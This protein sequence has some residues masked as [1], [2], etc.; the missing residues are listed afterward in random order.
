M[1]RLQVFS[2]GLEHFAGPSLASFSSW[3]RPWWLK[4]Y[5]KSSGVF[6]L[7]SLLFGGP[8]RRIALGYTAYRGWLGVGT[9]FCILIPSRI[10]VWDLVY[11]VSCGS[12]RRIGVIFMIRRIWWDHTPYRSSTCPDGLL[13]ARYA[14]S[15]KG[16][17]RIGLGRDQNVVTS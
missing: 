1:I 16:I 10:F 3:D 17:R 12:I 7:Y 5:P 6:C 11:G 13:G 4:A 9:T 2:Y 15:F 14:V 8:T